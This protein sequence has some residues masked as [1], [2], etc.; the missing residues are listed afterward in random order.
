MCGDVQTLS[1]GCGCTLIWRVRQ[2]L[3]RKLAFNAFM[4]FIFPGSQL[5]LVIG[6]MVSLFF[7]LV[8][9]PLHPHALRV[10]CGCSDSK[11]LL[12]SD[13]THELT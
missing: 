12:D 5:Q 8:G 2:E 7:L 11:G 9:A 10:S 4:A 6:F 1:R 13:D 3:F